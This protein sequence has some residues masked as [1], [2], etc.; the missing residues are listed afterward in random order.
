MG[1]KR[2]RLIAEPDRK[3]AVDLIDEAVAAGARIWRACKVLEITVRT[4]QRWKRNKQQ[5]TLGDR[6]K[7]AAVERVP[8]NALSAEERAEILRVCNQPEYRS[9][10]PSQIVPRLA[11]AGTYIASESSF[12]RV[13]RDAGQVNRRGAAEAPREVP[14]PKGY[15]ARQPNQVW[16]WDITFLASSVRGQFYRL[17]LIEDIYSRKIVGWEV[18]TEERAEHASVLISK[19]CLAE[20]VRRNQLVLHADNGSPMK[21]A[22]MLATLQ[23]LGVVPSF[24][25]P[26]VSDDNPFSES[27]FRTLKYSPAY[28][29]K[30]FGSLEEARRWV[31]EF[32]TWYNH[33]HRH[34][35]IKFV[36]PAQ[37]HD[38]LD[39]ELLQRRHAVYEKAKATNPAR[40][41][42][43]TRNWDP[44]GPTWLNP[45]KDLGDCGSVVAEAA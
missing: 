3:L 1:G 13:L 37:R 20:G 30:P 39:R 6:R 41:S 29:R 33:E 16:S 17:Y 24:S 43:G 2:G 10:P 35:A 31:H 12:Y 42:R 36:T 28:P 22:T 25:R 23:R 45:P 11:D 5:G 34:S 32:V 44:A 18:H 26:S 21:G 15:C 14:K 27:L 19:A 4:F 7:A 38:G 40:W 8:G 9:L